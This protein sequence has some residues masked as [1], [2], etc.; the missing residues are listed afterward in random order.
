[1]DT[2]GELSQP[3]QKSSGGKIALFV[4]CGCLA[5]ILIGV[6]GVAAIVFGVFGIIKNSD[7]YQDTLATAQSN[8]AVIEALGE[9]V[10]PGFSMSGSININNGVGDADISF[11]VS[12]PKAS[13][14]IHA[15]AEKPAGSKA[16]NY[17]TRELRLDGRDEVIPLGP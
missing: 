8:P 17:T 4:G 12:G 15:V 10:E 11:P 7:V 6:G 16:W 3:E 9:P 13:G 14:K 5:V 2:V 1:M